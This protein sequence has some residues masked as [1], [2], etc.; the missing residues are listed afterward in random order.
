MKPILAVNMKAYESAFGERALDVARSAREVANSYNDIR[1]ILVANPL[2]ASRLVSVYEDLYIQHADPVGFGAYTGFLPPGGVK[3]E[4][5]RGVLLNHSE[6]KILYR[7]LEKTINMARDAGLEVMT[8]ADTPGEAASIAHLKPDMI[9]LEPPELIG[10]G[11]P[12]S[13]AKPDVITRGVSTV[14]S[15]DEE[16]LVL[17]GAGITSGNDALRALELGAQG[18]LVASTVMKS[19]EPGKKMMELAEWMTRWVKR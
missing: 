1:L 12:V 14:K 2:N 17:A 8:C 6:H 3:L 18:V 5:I 16:I 19:R 9:A 15:I 11:I 13:R 10:T 7:D 4:G